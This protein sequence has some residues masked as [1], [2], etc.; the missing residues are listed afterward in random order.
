M[1][2][3]LLLNVHKLED[4]KRKSPIQQR[5]DT[6]SDH[7]GQDEDGEGPCRC[8]STVKFGFVFRRYKESIK[9]N[10]LNTVAGKGDPEPE[11][12]YAQS[13]NDTANTYASYLRSHFSQQPPRLS[14]GAEH[15]FMNNLR[16]DQCSDKSLH[17]TF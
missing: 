4:K 15:R 1:Q 13:P 17:S 16:S 6:R 7:N 8:S 9:F 3:L 10:L 5:G 12:S 2:I 11:F 14:R